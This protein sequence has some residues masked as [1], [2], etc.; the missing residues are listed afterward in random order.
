[1]EKGLILY[2]DRAQSCSSQLV[3]LSCLTRW[4][5]NNDQVRNLLETW[6][7]TLMLKRKEGMLVKKK[8]GYLV[9]FWYLNGCLLPSSA[10]TQPGKVLWLASLLLNA[11]RDKSIAS[12][13]NEMIKQG[14]DKPQAHRWC[15]KT[16]HDLVAVLT[17]S[18]RRPSLQWEWGRCLWHTQG[19]LRM[20][21]VCHLLVS[22]ISLS[23]FS[24]ISS[25]LPCF[26]AVVWCLSSS[27]VLSSLS[28]LCIFCSSG[29]GEGVSLLPP[30]QGHHH[31]QIR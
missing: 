3:L 22:G 23:W 9:M 17:C 1:M 12:P 15:S 18:R 26:C 25:S 29:M 19:C 13:M 20:G 16:H 27:F 14:H 11:G 10:L 6:Q 8:P 30:K 5:M 2:A 28:L 24:W 4:C 31:L 21:S 7:E